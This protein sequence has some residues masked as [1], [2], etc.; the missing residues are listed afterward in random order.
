MAVIRNYCI[1]S[2][3]LIDHLRGVHVARS[4]FISESKKQQ[5]FWISA[6][7][8]AEVYT[9]KETRNQ[10]EL[11]II[12]ELL[13]QFVI[14]DVSTMNAKLGGILRR[15]YNIPFADAII[16]ATALE[17]K[18]EFFTRNIKH[19]DKIKGLKVFKPY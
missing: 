19:F 14:I 16:A 5:G 11:R 1:D 12:D 13:E 17:N 10:K 3:I 15:D 18:L 7:S 9:G 4:F 6:V 2:D 8:V